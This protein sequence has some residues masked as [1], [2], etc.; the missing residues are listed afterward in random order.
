MLKDA[1]V[2]FGGDSNRG[3]LISQ[4]KYEWESMSGRQLTLFDIKMEEMSKVEW[5]ALQRLA[6]G[7]LQEMD[8]S[9]SYGMLKRENLVMYV[10]YASWRIAFA[11][12]I[13]RNVPSCWL[14]VYCVLRFSSKECLSEAIQEKNRSCGKTRY[15][16]TMTRFNSCYC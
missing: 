14:T 13:A 7:R 1:V 3:P 5:E 16:L 15:M 8:V 6:I 9:V 12:K 11:F 2:A 10:K 4:H